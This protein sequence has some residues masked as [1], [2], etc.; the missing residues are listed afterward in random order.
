MINYT[1]LLVLIFFIDS[2]QTVSSQE[3]LKPNS[4]MK[5]HETL[6]ISSIE[7]SGGKTIVNMTVENRIEGGNFCADRNIFITDNSGNRLKLI[8]A[9]NIPECPK[10][11][12]FKSVGD[13]LSFSLEFPPLN[14]GTAWIDII[15]EC[16]DNCFWFYGVTL[17]ALLNKELNEAFKS[18]SGGNPEDNILLFR[19]ILEEIDSS[20]HGIEGL[21]YVN[22]INEAVTAG[23]QAEASVWYKRLL[24]SGAPR[25]STY[26]KYLN[27][28]G[29]KYL[30]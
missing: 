15:E 4:A 9:V 8:K 5:S 3:I 26:V 18:A 6:E 1:Q 16:S 22:I 14:P 20:N 2:I 19:K 25:L 10:T 17:D 28:R 27:D 29:I 13:K 11:H 7:F 12:N 21:L 24:A 30:P 23:D